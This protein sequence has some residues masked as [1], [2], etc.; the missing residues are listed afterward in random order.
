MD[1]GA[2]FISSRIR[3]RIWNAD[4]DPGDK[5][6]TDPDPKHW[7]PV[8]VPRKKIGRYVKVQYTVYIFEGDHTRSLYHEVSVITVVI[9]I[10]LIKI[11]YCVYL[12]TV[13]LENEIVDAE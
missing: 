2:N 9:V 13:P 10:Q 1:F 8:P 4:P 3:I 7:V 5:F 12:A 11:L 6:N